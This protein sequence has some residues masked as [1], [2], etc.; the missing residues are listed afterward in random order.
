MWKRNLAKGNILTNSIF[1]KA[2]MFHAFISDGLGPVH[3]CLIVIEAGR[4]WE[5]IEEG[6]TFGE[7]AECKDSFGELVGCVHFSLAGT[8]H[9]ALL[10]EGGPGNQAVK[11]HN[12]IAAHGSEFV[13]FLADAKLLQ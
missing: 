3:A 13:H 1:T 11:V 7:V 8:A 9:S 2:N 5:C 12:E 4:Q 6:K 10:V